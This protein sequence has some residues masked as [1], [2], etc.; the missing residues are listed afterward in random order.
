MSG[1]LRTKYQLIQVM[2]SADVRYQGDKAL[3]ADR[4]S[5][6]NDFGD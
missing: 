2:V 1:T 4:L 3:R 5:D 6:L